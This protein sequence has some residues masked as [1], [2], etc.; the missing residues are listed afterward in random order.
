[1]DFWICGRT[2]SLLAFLSWLTRF[3]YHTRYIIELI[4]AIFCPNISVCF[5]TNDQLI[6]TNWSLK[7]SRRWVR[8]LLFPLQYSC[9][10][11]YILPIL[12][13]LSLYHQSKYYSFY[14]PLFINYFHLFLFLFF[15]LF[16]GTTCVTTLKLTLPSGLAR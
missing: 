10:Y 6:C 15:V 9:S 8:Y 1:M 16:G 13:V 2:N 5:K 12:I 4:N 14:K 3:K 11:S 7:L